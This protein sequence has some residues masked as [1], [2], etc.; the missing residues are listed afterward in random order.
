MIE[1]LRRRGIGT[2]VHF[3]PLSM[4][5]YYRR[6]YHFRKNDFPNAVKHFGSVISLPLYVDLRK[7]EIRYIAAVFKDI[8]ARRRRG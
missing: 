4:Q 1:S 5:P 6:K 2:S 8:F 3:I 7:P